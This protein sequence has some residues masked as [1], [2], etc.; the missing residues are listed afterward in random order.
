MLLKKAWCGLQRGKC[1]KIRHSS[2]SREMESAETGSDTIFGAQVCQMKGA[3]SK[4]RGQARHY[5]SPPFHPQQRL[6]E[7]S[8]TT[9][10][11]QRVGARLILL[12]RRGW[13]LIRCEI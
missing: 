6:I 4:E 8:V 10:S 7:S 2:P 3:M 13:R 5:L 9:M 11:K 12:D 1:K